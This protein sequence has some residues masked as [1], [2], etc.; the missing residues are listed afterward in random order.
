METPDTVNVEALEALLASEGWRLFRE[1]VAAEWSPSA[2]WKRVKKA[3]GSG[4]ELERVDFTNEQVGLLMT[5]PAE[6]IRRRK[7]IDGAAQVQQGQYAADHFNW[8]RRGGL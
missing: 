1:H 2:C 6:E 3:G 8:S 5:W 7:R 4:L